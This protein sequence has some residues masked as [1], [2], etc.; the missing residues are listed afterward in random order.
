M[1]NATQVATATFKTSSCRCLRYA[2]QSQNAHAASVWLYMSVPICL[3]FAMC[4]ALRSVSA[5]TPANAVVVSRPSRLSLV[6]R[7]CASCDK[8][9][10]TDLASYLLQV[11]PAELHFLILHYLAS[12]PC[13]AA[14]RLLEQQALEHRLLPSRHDISGKS[15]CSVCSLIMLEH[16]STAAASV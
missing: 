8:R 11:D 4:P 3:P 10:A 1:Q 16:D 2:P 6:S 12:G 13:T 7:V 5:H 9:H 14:A 15:V